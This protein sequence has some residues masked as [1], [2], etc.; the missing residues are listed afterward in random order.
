MYTK[1]GEYS[2][3]AFRQAMALGGH[4]G[5]DIQ[6]QWKE[7]ISASRFLTK[8]WNIVRF[9]STHFYND[10][11]SLQN[12]AYRNADWWLFSKLNSL[13]TEVSQD[14]DNY[15]FDS[16]LKKLRDF[17]WH[18]LADNY[19][20]LVKGR[21]YGEQIPEKSAA[22]HTLYVTLHA[23][24]V[25]LS[26]F[27]PFI[28]EE[29]YSRLP[30][31]TNSVHKSPWPT[32]ILDTLDIGFSGDLL[33]DIA[34]SVRSWKANSGLA[35]NE[36]ISNVEIYAPGQESIDT[37][38][39]SAAINAPVSLKSG[40]PDLILVP[41]DVEIDYSLIGPIFRE[42]SD[43]VVSAIKKLP[44]SEIKL[45]LEANGILTL[46]IDDSEISISQ[47]AIKLIEEYQTDKG[48]EVNVLTVPHAT[49]LLH[50]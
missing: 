33:I 7:V 22:L 20:E 15:R 32:P 17:I 34:Q 30:Q 4:P 5:S 43:T 8:L 41:S 14:M 48:K 25:M 3:D 21:I 39:L 26:P 24:I 44:L 18:D 49:I 23:L 27:I 10:L 36:K 16:A 1:D 11:P 40:K 45:Q 35:L 13:I 12:P 29:L 46:V 9:S 6:F 19:I 47:D 50:L 28:S 38:D 2:A 42:K 37:L 31:T